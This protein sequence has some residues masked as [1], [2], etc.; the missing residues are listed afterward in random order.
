MKM[1]KRN[2]IAIVIAAILLLGGGAYYFVVV[3][4]HPAAAP[5][6]AANDYYT[7]S[8]HPSV[9]SDHPGACPICGDQLVLAS[10]LSTAASSSVSAI[11]DSGIVISASQRVLANI[12]TVAARRT[13]FEKDINGVGVIDYAEPLQAVVSARFKGRIER[14]Y[15]NYTGE[16]VHKGQPL[17]DLYSPDLVSAEQDYLL[18]WQSA[19]SANNADDKRLL[20]LSREKLRNHYGLTDEQIANIEKTGTPRYSATFY[21]PIHG[22]VTAKQLTEGMYVDEGM[23]IYQ[24][25]DL[26]KVWAYMDVYESDLRFVHDDESAN[27]S[28]EAYPDETFKGKVAFI[29][30]VVNPQTRTVR[31]RVELPNPHGKLKPQMYAH[32]AIRI[33]VPDALVV[34]TSAVMTTGKRTVVWVEMQPNTF[35]P[36]DVETGARTDSLTQIVGGLSADEKVAAS[37]GYLIDSESQLQRGTGK[38]S[39]TSMKGKDDENMNNMPGMDMK[40]SGK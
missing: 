40:G 19:R 4:Q 33:S 31:V 18:A 39:D 30:P 13:T 26:S 23:Q 37:G 38:E 32:G 14:L 20:D 3:R 35:Q 15:V 16:E 24:L 2:I 21:S 22:T 8:M 10:S 6:A 7:C 27:I 28:V 36:R 1:N 25:A 34:P 12:T 9:H 29:D 17:F 5:I 11:P